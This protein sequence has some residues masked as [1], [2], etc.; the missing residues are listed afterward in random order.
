ME[1]EA[2]PDIRA[3]AIVPGDRLLLCSDGLNR[4]LDDP[5]ISRILEN[6]AA[7]SS[8]AMAL[9]AAANHAGGKDN[10]TAIVVDWKGSR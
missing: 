9:I 1:G 2:S 4:A 6:H 8:A 7:P 3:I 5:A 10:V